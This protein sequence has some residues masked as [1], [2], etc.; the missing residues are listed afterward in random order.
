MKWCLGFVISTKNNSVILLRKAKTLHVG[1]WNGL[2]GKIEINESP[3]EAMTR[4]CKEESGLFIPSWTCVGWLE[5][6][7]SNWRVEVYTTDIKDSKLDEASM[8]HF[9]DIQED[10]ERIS[11]RAYEVPLVD[12]PRMKLAPYTGALIYTCLDKLRNY[13]NTPIIEIREL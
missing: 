8:P 13:S 1:M 7:F 2:G 6:L 3:P 12:L 9:W 5:G 11:D 10:S 4:E